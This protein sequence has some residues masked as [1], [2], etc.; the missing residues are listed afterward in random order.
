MKQSRYS[1][2]RVT[3]KHVLEALV[4]SKRLMDEYN[5][6]SSYFL[7][8]FSSWNFLRVFLVN[9]EIIKPLHNSYAW[10]GEEPNEELAKEYV[11]YY[12]QV[13]KN[14]KSAPK[15]T[16]NTSPNKIYEDYVAL[17]KELEKLKLENREMFKDLK[18]HYQGR[19]RAEKAYTELSKKIKSVFYE[20]EK[21]SEVFRVY[22]RAVEDDFIKFVK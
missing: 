10:R 14:E 18:E 19:V 15:V 22:R 7:S 21:D 17:Q 1:I 4:E 16:T 13:K 2:K 5:F 3:P 9:K 12:N 11:L 6:L 20:P 8:N